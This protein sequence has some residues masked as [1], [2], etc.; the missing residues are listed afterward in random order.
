MLL[1]LSMFYSV[2]LIGA[3]SRSTRE[4]RPLR[5]NV[6]ILDADAPVT[7]VSTKGQVG[8]IA[9]GWNMIICN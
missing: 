2:L 1:V 9:K 7:D 3:S 6:L 4:F 5:G 8:H